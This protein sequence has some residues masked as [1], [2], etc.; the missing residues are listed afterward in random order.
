MCVLTPGL[1]PSAWS[2]QF[3]LANL[4]PV[5]P[6][7]DDVAN[8]LFHC[9]CHHY[10]DSSHFFLMST[11]WGSHIWSCL[12]PRVQ[13]TWLFL[14]TSKPLIL[15]ALLPGEPLLSRDFSLN[16]NHDL[17]LTGQVFAQSKT[18]APEMWGNLH[19]D[20]IHT[21]ALYFYILIILKKCISI[22]LFSGWW[23]VTFRF[24]FS[25]FLWK[26]KK[27]CRLWYSWISS[28]WKIILGKRI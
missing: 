20:H 13:S 6:F 26:A 2:R 5:R 1:L 3:Q 19:T 27:F 21:F 17:A 14:K 12:W 22:Y 25:H 7:L 11:H 8:H 23:L 18:W 24:Y 10:L 16:H 15:L 9:Y 4:M 28:S